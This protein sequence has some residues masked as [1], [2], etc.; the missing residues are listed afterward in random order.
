MAYEQFVPLPNLNFQINRVLSNGPEGC[1]EEELW[2]IAPNLKGFDSHV[3]YQQWHKLA[4]R[5]ETQGRFMHAAYY[6]RMSE[7][8]LPDQNPEKNTSY[9]AFQRCFYAAVG[10]ASLEK[11]AVPYGGGVLSALRMKALREKGV[12]VLHGGFDSFMEEFY[13]SLR[14]L[15]EL[16]YTV[17]VFEG[18]GQGKPLRQGLKMDHQ[19]EKPVS[20]ILDHFGLD[21]VCLIG[22]S[23]GGYLAL[24]AAAY[25]PRIT[26]V[27]AFDVVWDAL[28]AFAQKFHPDLYEQVVSKKEGEVN[29][30]IE[31]LRKGNDMVDWM[32]NHGMY[33]TG[34]QSP[35]EYL[36]KFSRFTTR[37]ISSL[38][39]QDVLLLAGE[40]DHFVPLEFYFEQKQALINAR[41]IRGRLFLSGEGGDQHCQIG[42]LDLAWNK[43]IDWLDCFYTR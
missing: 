2:E 24:R 23:L 19:W 37:D 20:A 9:K 35:F 31:K 21:Q 13:L 25:D 34:G 11:V 22:I 5:A 43:I 33:I 36:Y 6:H 26:R 10:K 17:I 15:P 3:W 12:V 40:N 7:F 1:R 18:P 8:F 29:A 42:D 38:I 27:V 14:R 4:L 32:V 30:F 28:A 16:G 39:R 41:S